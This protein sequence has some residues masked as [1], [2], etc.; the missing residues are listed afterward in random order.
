M[1]TC[2]FD[3]PPYFKFSG[4]V[5]HF[6]IWYDEYDWILETFQRVFW[7]GKSRI[8]ENGGKFSTCEI[9]RLNRALPSVT[10]PCYKRVT[11]PEKNREF[12]SKQPSQFFLFTFLSLQFKFSIHSCILCCLIAFPSEP[13][14]YFLT[15][16][17]GFKLPIT[18]RESTF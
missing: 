17:Y 7:F 18:R 10:R 8:K 14:A 5:Q 2:N 3:R 4:P 9:R 1:F 6:H 16:G 13:F 12:I 11:S 15:S